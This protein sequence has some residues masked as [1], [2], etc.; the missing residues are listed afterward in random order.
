MDL[1]KTRVAIED[2]NKS[3]NEVF[4]NLYRIAKV[5]KEKSQDNRKKAMVLEIEKERKEC[6]FSPDLKKG[7]KT[8][9]KYVG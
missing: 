5:Q 7:P 9:K 2:A 3:K 1:T 4:T 8:M 6:T